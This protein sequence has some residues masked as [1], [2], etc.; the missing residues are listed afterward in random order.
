VKPGPLERLLR[1]TAGE[2]DAMAGLFVGLAAL[3]FLTA[4]AIQVAAS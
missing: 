4:L 2:R 1:R 3:L